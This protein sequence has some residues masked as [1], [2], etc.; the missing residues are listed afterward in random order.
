MYIQYMNRI[1][2]LWC[3]SIR[4][5]LVSAVLTFIQISKTPLAEFCQCQ[6]L[7][8]PKLSSDLIII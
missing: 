2:D 5:F 3:Q 6:L 8:F 7:V 4:S 1:K